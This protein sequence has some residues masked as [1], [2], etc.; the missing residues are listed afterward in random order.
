MRRATMPIRPIRTIER[1]QIHLLQSIQHEPRQMVLRQPIPRA[2]RH[3]RTL[4]TITRQ[5]VLGHPQILLNQSDRPHGFM[6]QPH[7]GGK[8]ALN[9]VGSGAVRGAGVNAGHLVWARHQV[10]VGS[11]RLI[12]PRPGENAPVTVFPDY[13]VSV[14][15]RVSFD[16]REL[17]EVFEQN[18][19]AAAPPPDNLIADGP[20]T[21]NDPNRPDP[22]R[23]G[24]SHALVARRTNHRGRTWR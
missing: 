20:N 8:V 22:P 19:Q 4:I 7:A 6:R 17:F 2:R 12:A 13:G 14:A 11:E 16:S 3:Q 24:L 9:R 5:K 18:P 1:R 10:A 23:R 21:A 15:P